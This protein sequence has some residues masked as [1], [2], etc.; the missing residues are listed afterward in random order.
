MCRRLFVAGWVAVAA[1]L[2]GGQAPKAP[3][4]PWAAV[5]TT[6]LAVRSG[7]ALDARY[8][9]DGEFL[10][11]ADDKKNVQFWN[12]ATGKE[13]RVGGFTPGDRPEGTV[14]GFSADGTCL[15]CSDLIE[16]GY[17]SFVL[18][19]GTGRRTGGGG[20]S[21]AGVV[22]LCHIT[23]D[24]RFYL[25]AYKKFARFDFTPIFEKWNPMPGASD[26]VVGT[27][28]KLPTAE[29]VRHILGVRCALLSPNSKHLATLGP[30][31][32]MVL[33]DT[34][35]SAP[36][37]RIVLPV[38]PMSFVAFSPDGKRLAAAGGSDN[39]AHVWTVA[40]G[41]KSLSLSGHRATV[42]SV[43]FSPDGR[44]LAT[45]SADQTVKVW[46]A[47]TGREAATLRGHTKPVR[48]VSFSP[49]GRRIAS[50]GEDGAVFVW[51]A[52]PPKK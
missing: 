50:A 21:A 43:A 52:S 48:R 27:S 13:K 40:G 16:G 51:T 32:A 46:D 23:T 37:V 45:S 17:N 14:I 41:K 10:V 4:N 3:A 33:W 26:N 9:P 29:L 39:Q 31:K 22:D 25:A 36:A 35:T 42:L 12:P 11:T 20:W 49:E 19:L 24:G 2:A 38:A 34:V 8:T 1:A 15:I 44:W 28:F 18:D 47:A 30:D 7:D 5:E 6:R